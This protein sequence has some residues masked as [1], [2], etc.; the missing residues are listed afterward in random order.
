MQHD[1]VCGARHR[2]THTWLRMLG[3]CIALKIPLCAQLMLC[4]DLG[5][6][7]HCMQLLMGHVVVLHGRAYF[8]HRFHLLH[9]RIVC[10][11]QNSGSTD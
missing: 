8:A 3:I 10:L 5:P 2:V 9:V 6:G 4:A 7:M 1:G 11:L